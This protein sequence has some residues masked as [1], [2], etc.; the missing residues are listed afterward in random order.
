MF[1]WS[2]LGEEKIKIYLNRGKQLIGMGQPGRKQS[3]SKMLEGNRL[4]AKQ[5]KQRNADK[6]EDASR[7]TF[8]ERWQEMK[9][10]TLL[11]E[12][13]IAYGIHKEFDHR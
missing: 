2:P 7:K 6:V 12:L 8:N 9:D 13:L 4:I 1:S 10:S 3:H 11:A 5:C